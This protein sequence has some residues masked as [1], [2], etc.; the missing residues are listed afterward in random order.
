ML[1]FIGKLLLVV[2]E[3]VI[4]DDISISTPRKR[5]RRDQ[6]KSILNIS[7]QLK[8]G[9]SKNFMFFLHQSI[10]VDIVIVFCHGHLEWLDDLTLPAKHRILIY[11]KCS[12]PW[13]HTFCTKFHCIPAIFIDEGTSPKISSDEC[14]GYLLH[15]E[16]YFD[17][18]SDWTIFL[19]DDAPRHLH[20]AYLNMVLKLM[21]FGTFSSL[22]KGT[23]SQFL[24]LNNDRHLLYW[25]PCLESIMKSLGLPSTRVATYC[26]SQFVVHRTQILAR[27]AGFFKKAAGLLK[28]NLEDMDGCKY[29]TNQ[30]PKDMAESKLQGFS[31]IRNLQE[32]TA[33]NISEVS[34]FQMR[35]CHLYE[36]G[37]KSS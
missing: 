20:L 16:R 10:Q 30:L 14:G 19:Q 32:R 3:I 25:T 2:S 9:S 24:H 27:G 13:Q 8:P 33:R 5:K 7:E 17:D 35:I 26:C 18:L 36:A 31:D 1:L 15:I 22:I 4:S 34:T 23:T 12:D 37:R 28:E 11:L 29:A 6:L 21:A